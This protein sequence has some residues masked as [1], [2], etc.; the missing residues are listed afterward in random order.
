MVDPIRIPL[1][2]DMEPRLSGSAKDGLAANV[3]YDKSKS[4]QVYATKRPGIT[5]NTAGSG[6]ALG[7]Y[8]DKFFVSNN[9]NYWKDAI[10][11][12]SAFLVVAEGDAIGTAGDI[13]YTLYSTDG[14]TYSVSA[15]PPEIV[16]GELSYANTLG[17]VIAYSGSAYCIAT[18]DQKIA[19]STN[20]KVWNRRA[21]VTTP[22]DVYSIAFGNSN[23]VIV[24]Q[25]AIGV[26]QAAYS[27]D[28]GVTWTGVTIGGST[29][30]SAVAYSSS[31]ILFC[32]VSGVTGDKAYTSPTGA[33]WT[34]RTLP[35]SG[36]RF[37]IVSNGTDFIAPRFN[38][39]IADTSSDGITWGTVTLP[40]TKDWQYSYWTGELYLIS[41]GLV[42]AYSSD[43]VTWAQAT[44]PVIADGYT[45]VVGNSDLLL[46]FASGKNYAYST[47]G[48][49]V[50]TAATIELNTPFPIGTF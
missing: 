4:G 50:W 5:L 23:F 13:D 19:T 43:G 41:D 24:G 25:S 47:N 27:S 34:Q 22:V 20:G 35:A 12:G 15:F 1:V 37:T 30:F 26:G 9:T 46:A 14:T 31:D 32:A 42:V 2:E 18:L 7:I 8:Q 17:Q 11:T 40:S 28:S 33:V 6:L 44:L 45:L 3:F 36:R 49:S 21:N 48:G 10:W 38:S 39:N 16:N 29:A